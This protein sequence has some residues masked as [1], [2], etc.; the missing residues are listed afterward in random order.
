M[1]LCSTGVSVRESLKYLVN[2][3]LR[4][5][6][7]MREVTYIIHTVASSC[8]ILGR[9]ER[10]MIMYR[11]LNGS[12]ARSRVYVHPLGLAGMM[13]PSVACSNDE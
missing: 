7:A 5:S 1:D 11:S 6:E 8:H 4:V 2:F 3:R 13:W 10:L 9:V 12:I